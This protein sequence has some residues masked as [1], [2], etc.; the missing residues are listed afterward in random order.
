MNGDIPTE[1]ARLQGF[2]EG[3]AKEDLGTNDVP[4]MRNG[5]HGVH[6]GVQDLVHNDIHNSVQNGVQ[7]RV[8]KGGRNGWTPQVDDFRYRGLFCGMSMEQRRNALEWQINL[9]GDVTG[10][11]REMMA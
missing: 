11:C 10:M 8:Q 4:T 5:V 1:L 9:Y 6:Y 7:N 2:S 3:E